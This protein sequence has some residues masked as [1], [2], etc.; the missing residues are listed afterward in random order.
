[1]HDE[2]SFLFNKP[3]KMSIKTDKF[4]ERYQKLNKDNVKNHI[5]NGSY[6]NDNNDNNPY[7]EIINKLN[8]LK[9]MELN[10]SDFAYLVDLGV[11]PVNRLIILRR[12]DENVMVKNDLNDIDAKP[13]STL[14]SWITPDDEDMFSMSF[15]EKWIDQTKFFWEVISDVVKNNTGMDVSHFSSLP[16]WS[17]GFLYQMLQ[18]ANI[19][20][21]DKND[22]NWMP[23]GDPDV[24]RSS[25]TRDLNGSISSD[26]KLSFNSKYEQ[27]YI[28][29]IDSG[30][31]MM[32]ILNNIIR[33]GISDMKFILKSDKT[34]NNLTNS[35][36]SNQGGS[37][38]DWISGIKSIIKSFVET[39]KNMFGLK[40]PSATT[41]TDTDKKIYDKTKITEMIKN[42]LDLSIK[43]FRWDLKS[44]LALTTGLPTTPWHVTV[45]NPL[46]PILSI[47][48]VVV[49]Q[50]NIK[51]GNE[52]NFND[53]PTNFKV[54]FD[55]DFGR[56]LGRSELLEILNINYERNYNNS[57]NIGDVDAI[58]G[59]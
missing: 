57:S 4:G 47:G 33:M 32:T 50:G 40:N 55:I 37:M 2:M 7:L 26:I 8:G 28:G 27:K 58:S 10:Y 20:N 12:F 25:K 43:R 22:K 35:I 48:N 6:F 31:A 34:L 36:Y 29:G 52:F 14:V 13:I 41:N 38:D 51:F 53:M 23:V 19:G 9:S 21:Y 46:N 49:D 16:A 24:L 18:G 54:S 30:I 45:G 17:Q 3:P 39:S 44:S 42:T 56:P 59:A 15:S 1:M 5:I 11:Y